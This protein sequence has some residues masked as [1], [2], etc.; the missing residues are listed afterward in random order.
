MKLI[1]LIL[2]VLIYFWSLLVYYEL[3]YANLWNLN[4]KNVLVYVEILK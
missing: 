4:V 1:S 2:F 3:T